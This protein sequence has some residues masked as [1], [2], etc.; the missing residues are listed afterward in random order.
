ME[1]P[2]RR[3]FGIFQPGHLLGPINHLKTRLKGVY[4]D[5]PSVPVGGQR[6]E[7]FTVAGSCHVLDFGEQNRQFRAQ[8]QQRALYDVRGGDV[9]HAAAA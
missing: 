2:R 3:R 4:V 1:L 7:Q 9:F 8:F 5:E 6:I